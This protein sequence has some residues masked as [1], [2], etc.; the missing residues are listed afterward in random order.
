MKG[1]LEQRDKS[2]WSIVLELGRDAAGKRMRRRVTFHGTK[3]QAQDELARLIHELNTGVS[4]E[5]Q[6][7]DVGE[8]LE[9]WLRD[10]VAIGVAPRTGERYAE[11]VRKHLVPAFGHLKLAKLRPLHITAYYSEALKSGRL[12][13]KGGLSAQ[14][15]LHHHR[16][17]REALQ[18]AVKWR[19]LAV[20]PADAVEPPRPQRNE[21][22][23]L[24]ETETV[25]LLAATRDTKLHVPVLL[26][27]TTG[28][29]A[30]ELLAVRWQDVDLE[31]GTLSVVQTLQSTKAG[32]IF[33][34]PKTRRSR[35]VVKLLPVAVEALREHRRDQ[36]EARLQAGD[37]YVDHD[38][39]F[40]RED[41]APWH[42]GTFANDWKKFKRAQGLTLRFHDL[43]HTHAT[44]LLRQGVH[45]KVVSE[46]LGHSS[47]GITLDTYSHVLPDMQED[48]AM[49]LETA[50]SRAMGS[51]ERDG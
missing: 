49:K 35:R 18:Q 33:G 14:T 39:V 10:Y 37:V 50:L 51:G 5:P 43:R 20:N 13:G 29:R 12:D 38:L 2:R 31:A 45:P 11:I 46:R 28:L 24:T 9:I 23:V 32:L 16:V 1:H 25:A 36:V 6:R 47:V 19:L 44:L 30:G 4:V 21:M 41:G 42:P 34:Q 8:Y 3:R 48:A 27:V 17:L 26:A 22:R 7:L 15:V 40:G